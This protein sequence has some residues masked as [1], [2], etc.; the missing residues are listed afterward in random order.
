MNLLPAVK[1]RT[2]VVVL[3]AMTVLAPSASSAGD[4]DD[5]VAATNHTPEQYAATLDLAI[6][7]GLTEIGPPPAITG[8]AELDAR[9][10]AI[11]EA[12]GYQRRPEANR[13]LVNVGRQQLQPEAAVG[14]E[15]LRDAAAAAGH[16]LTIL[17][18][19][20][21]ASTQASFLRERIIGT[22][23]AALDRT[24]RTV[25]PP[26]YSKHHTGYTIDIRSST[27]SGFDFRNSA[28]YEWLAAEDFANAK[29][30]GWI[31]SY[32]EGAT[33]VGPVPEPW[34][35]VWVGADNII[36]GD[37][38]AS[39]IHPFC[40]TYG[41]N[42]GADIRW[43]A[44]REITDGCRLNRYCPHAVISRGEAATMIWRMAGSTPPKVD[45]INFV[46]VLPDRFYSSA[47]KWMVDNKL[48]TGKTPTSFVPTGITTKAQF[49]TYLWRLAGEPAPARPF[50][51]LDV[52]PDSFS[53]TAIAWA[54]ETG[55]S[56][57]TSAT[58]FSPSMKV[59]RGA[60]SA[61]LHRFAIIT[62][63]LQLPSHGGNRATL[64]R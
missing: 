12:R 5:A 62:D 19:Y 2:W 27:A 18:G 26:G 7:P 15:S 23:D 6:L 46:D 30:H 24:L 41:S 1:K 59:T 34:E 21:R 42:F 29:A 52:D 57:S 49:V 13:P 54:F 39:P 51:F 17:S 32:P 14:W 47:V 28:A 63:Q 11:A 20:R 43:L 8:N 45:T 61:F 37:F 35:F 44:G 58:T 60:A 9:I 48:T 25:A 33:L 56:P 10:R 31:P 4:V 3:L 22:S 16:K 36:C 50:G 53:A 64:L 55:I 38:Q 40:D